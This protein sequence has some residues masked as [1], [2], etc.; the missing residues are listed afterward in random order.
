[1][2][3]DSTTVV[4]ARAET[5]VE[6]GGPGAKAPKRRRGRPRKGEG[7]DD[8]RP[9]LVA[10]AL[11]LF[12]AKG[13]DGVSLAEIAKRAG[14]TASLVHYYFESKDELWKTALSSV[15]RELRDA[16]ERLETQL[17][18]EDPVDAL[19]QVIRGFVA[20]SS[21]HPEVSL[22]LRNERGE[23]G[24]RLE[25]LWTEHWAPLR[26][27]P[28]GFIIA[29]Q[30]AGEIREGAPDHI[31]QIIIGAC[32]HP[33]RGRLSLQQM[34]GLDHDA[35]EVYEVHADLV[36]ATLMAGLTRVSR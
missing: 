7:S 3:D 31:L 35:Q 14:A 15:L 28:L 32:L 26:A 25:W 16:F 27:L 34:Y 5:G 18:G 8:A 36:S 11:E 13:F 19:E 9:A 4:S 30:Q 17:E 23:V 21:R 24:P 33:L 20:F 2:E 29:G 22:I 10:A 12:A 6:A 1:M